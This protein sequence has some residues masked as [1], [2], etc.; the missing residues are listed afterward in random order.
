MASRRI[1][2]VSYFYPPCTDTG[3]HRPTALAKYL[4]RGGHDVTVLTTSAYGSLPSDADEGVARTA[5][6]QLWREKR[7]GDKHVGSLYDADTYSGRPHPLSKVIVPEP[8]ALAWAP[9]ARRRARSLN[10][11]TPFDCVITTSP[12]E[13]AHSVGWALQRQGVAWVADVRDAWTF[14]PLRPSFLIA[15]L[16]RYDERLERRTLGAAD[17]VVCVS[18]PAA[19]DLRAR[20]IADPELVRNGADPELLKAADPAS[21]AGLL[22]P[23]RASLVYTGRFGSSGRDPGPLIDALTL[24]AAE[25]PVDAARLELV[26]AGPLTESERELMSRDVN[27]ARIRLVGSL[28]RERALALQ[29]AADCLLLLAH[30]V[31]TQLA[32]FK[33]YEY[34][35]AGPPI[36]ALA[37]GTEAGAIAE[38]IGAPAIPAG[39]VRAI[40]GGLGRAARRELPAS[41]Q[42]A[43]AGYAYPAVAERMGAAVEQAIERRRD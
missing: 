21:I 42:G 40:A 9:F 5:D 39:D 28:E 36:L 14:E 31:R 12:P 41:D 6:A 30:P 20:G 2:L 32:N 3:A 29:R 23:D 18:E 22:D 7:R 10:R 26:V 4:R 34:L 19:A 43:R 11:A 15:A 1:L 8:L 27:P 38:S 35:H 17:T 13:S 24:L 16:R 37:A 25:D 33:L